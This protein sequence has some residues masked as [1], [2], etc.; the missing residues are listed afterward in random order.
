[1]YNFIPRFLT[2]LDYFLSFINVAD[3]RIWQLE[4]PTAR[5]AKI[6]ETLTVSR[7][8]QFVPGLRTFIGIEVMSERSAPKSQTGWERHFWKKR[9]KAIRII[10]YKTW[11][12]N[13]CIHKKLISG[14]ICIERAIEGK[15]L[16]FFRNNGIFE[17]W[18]TLKIQSCQ[19]TWEN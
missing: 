17:F 19:E 12:C 18:I 15:A 2:K 7:E 8:W 16:K 5:D 4:T 6:L 3:V 10:T 1:M 14:H 9:W 11:V 13:V